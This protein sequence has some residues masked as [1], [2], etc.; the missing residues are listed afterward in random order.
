MLPGQKVLPKGRKRAELLFDAA[1]RNAKLLV[2]YLICL[3][4]VVAVTAPAVLIEI[5]MKLDLP[6]ELNYQKY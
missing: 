6:V 3:C 4:G 1:Q 2:S 5:K